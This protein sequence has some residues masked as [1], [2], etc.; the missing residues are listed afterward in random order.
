MRESESV[1]AFSRFPGFTLTQWEHH[2]LGLKTSE[3]SDLHLGAIM[4]VKRFPKTQH[5]PKK[6]NVTI[7]CMEYKN[8]M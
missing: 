6:V 3:E 1:R 4:K 8:Q 5:K 7:Q 2:I